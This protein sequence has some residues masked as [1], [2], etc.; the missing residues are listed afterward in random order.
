MAK[1]IEYAT[2]SGHIIS[3]ITADTEPEVAEGVSLLELD[4]DAEIEISRYVVK[5]GKLKKVYETNTEKSEQE[6]IKREYSESA[7]LRV[8][9]I[10]NELSLAML[11]DDEEEIKRL[12]SEYKRLKVYL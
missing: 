5:D 11:E 2:A 6:R 10:I 9:S 12:K 4:S 3:E 7:R 1:Y 8:K